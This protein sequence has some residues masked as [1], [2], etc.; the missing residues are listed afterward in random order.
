[1]LLWYYGRTALLGVKSEFCNL[2]D[3]VSKHV[4]VHEIHLSQTNP[5]VG[6][7][8]CHSILLPYLPYVQL[9][10]PGASECKR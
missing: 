9:M 4:L 2:N 7:L 8:S 10:M 3:Q 5:A 1:M 6:R